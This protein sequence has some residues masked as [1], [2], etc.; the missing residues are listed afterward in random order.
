[1]D[2]SKGSQKCEETKEKKNV[3]EK[4][5]DDT[6]K[7]MRSLWADKT[8][9]DVVMKNVLAIKECIDTNNAVEDVFTNIKRVLKLGKIITDNLNLS[10]LEWRATC[11]FLS[12]VMQESEFSLQKIN[13]LA[14][15]R[16]TYTEIFKKTEGIRMWNSAVGFEANL[17]HSNNYLT[18]MKDDAS[19]HLIDSLQNYISEQEIVNF[20]TT[21]HSEAVTLILKSEVES[22]RLAS[23]IVNVYFRIAILH[24]FVL[25]QVL[26]IKIRS[27]FDESST[28]GVFSIVKTCQTSA[29]NLL[30]Y[31]TH[32]KAENVLFL[33]VF[34]ITENENVLHFLHIQ[35]IDPA[36]FDESFFAQSH[37]IQRVFK[38]CLKLHMKPR[39]YG[40]Y[41]T[42]E[43]TDGCKFN[44]EPVPGRE[45][46]NVCYIR[47]AHSEWEKYYIQMYSKGSCAAVS[48][49]P[50][51]GGKWKF[52]PL[53]NDK[54]H[55]TFIIS[56]I[57]WPGLFLYLGSYT[58]Y[59]SGKNDLEK[60]KKKGLWKICNL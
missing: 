51:T 9:A 38:P 17:L 48:E 21:L 36:V 16:S 31:I 6:L 4:L 28:Q 19:K 42:S 41:G 57:D 40:I 10:V 60:V 37:L 29:L 23:E 2:G 26:C 15:Q 45:L 46:D 54:Q 43:T 5:T 44:F 27:G 25:W 1:M 8:E 12:T 14:N 50:E 47:S 11:S 56:S 53:V 52:V 33:S 18:H 13:T 20:L 55:Q 30:E 24:L 58:G 7:E 59:V 22:A 35:D 34:H 49:R 3:L 32:Y 39:H